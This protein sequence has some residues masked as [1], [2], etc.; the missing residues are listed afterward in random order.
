MT[1]DAIFSMRVVVSVLLL[2]PL[3]GLALNAAQAAELAVVIPAPAVDWRP[4]LAL[5]CKLWFWRAAV[6]GACRRYS[7]IP[8][9]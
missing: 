2:L 7:S 5:D 8:K 9:A 3:A 4:P 1:R 6:F